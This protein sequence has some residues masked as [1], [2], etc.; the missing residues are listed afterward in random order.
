MTSAAIFIILHDIYLNGIGPESLTN[1]FTYKNKITNYR[2]RSI[3]SG[4]C[5][6]QP[7]T[8]SMKNSFMYDGAKLWN[9]SK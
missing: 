2:L 3:S 7:R 4:L 1:L 8:N 6:P 9:Y 5:P